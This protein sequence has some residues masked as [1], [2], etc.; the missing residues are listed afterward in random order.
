VGS[1]VLLPFHK[2][3]LQISA[4]ALSVAITSPLFRSEL[5][6]SGRP[7]NDPLIR[8][9]TITHQSKRKGTE[10][11]RHLSQQHQ[12]TSQRRMNSHETNA[13]LH[14]LQE[15]L[16]PGVGPALC[17]RLRFSHRGTEAAGT[18]FRPEH[19]SANLAYHQQLRLLE[20]AEGSSKFGRALQV[21]FHP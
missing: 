11:F 3:V 12:S 5:Q 10:Q 14:S 20:S 1:K 18:I 21:H 4:A 15:T 7:A 13:T 16:T 8:T 19:S 6:H 17:S 2:H 9:L